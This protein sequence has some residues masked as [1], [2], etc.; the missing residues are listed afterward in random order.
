LLDLVKEKSQEIK[1]KWKYYDNWPKEYGNCA[2]ARNI[3]LKIAEWD[4]LMTT[5]PELMFISDPIKQALDYFEKDKNISLASGTVYFSQ[6]YSQTDLIEQLDWN[7][8]NKAMEVVNKYAKKYYT[9]YVSNNWDIYYVE[10]NQAPFF[11]AYW[12]E[13]LLEQKGWNEDFVFWW[14][15][16]N[17]L[18]HRL[19]M[20]PNRIK[21]SNFSDIKVF[22]QFH[23]RPPQKAMW[24]CN[25]WLL[26]RL[27]LEQK[28]TCNEWDW[29]KYDSSKIITFN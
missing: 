2:K 5:E 26:D 21:H 17:E 14:N 4:I 16:D 29:W 25:Q 13:D 3:W 22:H 19:E 9:G 7:D 11:W 15:E 10:D 28:F 12:R 23:E 6:K 8:V 20:S 24:D 1:V 18:Q 27:N